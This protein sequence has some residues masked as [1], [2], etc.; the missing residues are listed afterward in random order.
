M[1]QPSLPPRI[2][3]EVCGMVRAV[4]PDVT[5]FKA[6]DAVS[7]IPGYSQSRYGA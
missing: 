1:E 3:Y 4:G 7:T 5:A 6:G 2:G